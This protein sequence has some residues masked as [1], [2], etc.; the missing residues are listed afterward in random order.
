MHRQS[1]A[2]VGAAAPLW[3]PRLAVMALLMAAAGWAAH[4]IRLETE[5]L[6]LLPQDLPSVRGLDGFSRQFA[7]D[8]ELIL[9]ADD[10]LPAARR[11]ELWARLRP[12]LA[13]LE[14]V[15]GVQEAGAYWLQLAPQ[16]AAWI[17]WNLPPERFADL[18]GALA[19]Q[20]VQG[21]LRRLPQELAGAFDWERLPLRQ[22]DPLDLLA[23]LHPGGGVAPSAPEAPWS[24]T[25]TSAR[26]LI[27]FQ[28]CADFYDAV[29]RTIA[30][31]VP[32]DSHLLITGRPAFT[33]EISA[34]MR[35]D[36]ILMVAVAVTLASLAF[37]GFY[38]SLKP[39][40]WILLAQFLALGAALLGARLGVGALNV[41]SMGFGC[42]LLG[43]GMDYSI[44]VYHHFASPY[45]AA[46]PAWRRLRRGIWFSATTTA[47]AFLVLAFAS[48]P[49]LR[50]LALLVAGGLLAAAAFATWLLPAAWTTRPPQAPPYL[51]RASAAVAG[52][53]EGHGR[54]LLALSLAAVAATGWR[55]G[56]DPAPLYSADLSRFQP[57]ASQAYRGERKLA[58]HDPSA[59][60]AI[61]LVE[62]ADWDAVRSAAEELLGRFPAG[63]AAAE[64][65]PAPARQ[66]ANRAQWPQDVVPRLRA[67]FAEAGLGE[68]WSRTTLAF[69]QTL[70]RAAT[71][72]G[73]A[74]AALAPVLARL[75]RQDGAVHRAV[76]RIPG[77]AA[78]PVPPAG[79][80]GTA[81]ELLP[82]SWVA[83][84]DELNASSRSDVQRLAGAALAAI[85]LL[86]AA[87]QRSLRLVLLN[88]AALALALLL[89][90]ALLYWTGIRLS[91]FSLLALP[92]LLGLSIDY[93][94]H[95]L[96]ALEHDRG[97]FHQ[98]YSHIGA[99]ILLTALASCI[100]FG[101][102]MLT[103]QPALQNFGLVMD[104]GIVAAVFVC[105]F[106]LPLLARA[107]ARP[108]PGSR[109]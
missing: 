96:M 45:R 90:A 21:K 10:A 65:I 98:L 33:A 79:L 42:I 26:P 74:F 68:E 7:S 16:L 15:Q 56:W 49:G 61:Y 69:C 60:D 9:V 37:W 18:T 63:A 92:L 57:S 73:D 80:G 78:N 6:A 13:A 70:D 107:S 104:L 41:I 81:A 100:G 3:W 58:A 102:P 95:V 55:L 82:V 108:Q 86:C 67:A 99:P 31:A 103:S 5:L 64:L 77:M 109:R 106:L 97:D 76:L 17:A 87:A 75:Q 38:R 22:F 34:Q 44:L 88:L 62:A 28:E 93:S 66:Q 94:L 23:A 71:G 4:S 48:L 85:V 83:L 52:A 43:I 101:A 91:A 47:A 12:A 40:G 14:D 2:N 27:T 35:H 20:P 54:W 105:L 19:A 8:R 50:Q 25:V 30:A 51:E 72:A 53:M 84:Q 39:L 36:M 24:L 1:V 89:L 32:G 29:A 46:P 59:S 11:A